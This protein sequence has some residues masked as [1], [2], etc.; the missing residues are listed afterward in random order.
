M[1][2]TAQSTNCSAALFALTLTEAP[3]QCVSGSV[4]HGLL[5]YAYSITNDNN[6][7]SMNFCSN[8][9]TCSSSCSA[10]FKNLPIGVCRPTMFGQF[11]AHVELRTTQ[12]L[13]VCRDKQPWPLSW[14][15][16]AVGGAIAVTLGLVVV[17]FQYRRRK[18]R[19]QRA[20]GPMS[21]GNG[22][23]YGTINN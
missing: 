14:I 19:Q 10:L 20:V 1:C 5:T 4:F 6:V 18:H 3:S 8:V 21:P 2:N 11:N 7:Y 17:V 13:V 9:T 22:Y 23:G 16:G 12:S 15:M